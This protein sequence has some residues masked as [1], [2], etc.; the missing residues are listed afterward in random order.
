MM[1]HVREVI[2]KTKAGDKIGD[3]TVDFADDFSY[4][5]PI[6]GSIASKQ[7]LRFVFADGSRIIFRSVCQCVVSSVHL[8]SL[9]IV[10]NGIFWGD[11]S[12]VHRAVLRRYVQAR[13]G[14]PRGS[15]AD[16]QDG[17]RDF[18]ASG[19][20]RTRQTDRHYLD[21]R[22]YAATSCCLVSTPSVIGVAM[23]P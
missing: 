7:G 20:H 11:D 21:D 14:F 23:Q 5:D 4:T 1:D 6:D 9:Q 19:I 12:F 17:S 15:G 8:S 2:S 18:E 3:Y 16:H 22:P 13:Y 10:W